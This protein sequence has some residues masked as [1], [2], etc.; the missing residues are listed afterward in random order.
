MLRTVSSFT[1]EPAAILGEI[2]RRLCGRTQGG[3][4]TCLAVRLD[5]DGRLAVA[6]AGHPAPYVNGAEVP[7]GG[8]MPVGLVETAMY[9]QASME[10]RTGDRVVL[11]TD[12]IPEARNEPGVLL[13]FPRVELMLREG[14][15]AKALAE[16]AK[17]QGQND[18]ITV[19]SI[20]RQ[21]HIAPAQ[22]FPLPA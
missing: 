1:E 7:F 11:L 18:D 22:K 16:T 10:M 20:A 17:Q 21:A 13:G 12:G 5:E 15:S 2:N 14:A 6:N 8:S 4:A 9:E 19:I 3:F